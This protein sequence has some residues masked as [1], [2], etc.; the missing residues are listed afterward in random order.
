M[1]GPDGLRV[2]GGRHDGAALAWSEARP[3]RWDLDQY[4][5]FAP[6]LRHFFARARGESPDI[7]ALRIPLGGDDDPVVTVNAEDEDE[8]ASLAAVLSTMR[9]AA[10]GGPVARDPRVLA[11]P[12]CGAPA[13]PTTEAEA[14]CAACGAAVPIPAE[15]RARLAAA[16]HASARRARDERAIARLLA[17]PGATSTNLAT[18][19]AGVLMVAAWPTATVL[20]LVDLWQTRDVGRAAAI[21]TLPIG[22]V[23]GLGGLLHARASGRRAL[24][25]VTLHF[26]AHAR[27]GEAPECRA[28]GG[29][30]PEAAGRAVVTCAYCEAANVVAL[31][32]RRTAAPAPEVTLGGALERVGRARVRA[33]RLAVG[34]ALLV[35]A[36]VWGAAALVGG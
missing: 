12:R 25:L 2:E 33:A 18:L 17:Q 19:A 5:F 29:P 8:A 14:P 26:A 27:D 32:A 11:C 15:L 35:G 22:L 16:A 7:W 10:A 23:L 6:T 36:T 3:E 21:L 31:R 28:C 9:A 20:A 30:L 34:G 24:Q 13:R 1:L 4:A